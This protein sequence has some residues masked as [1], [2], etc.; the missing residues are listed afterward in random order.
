[1]RQKY[2]LYY[3]LY[4]YSCLYSGD[5]EGWNVFV[6][7]SHL[8]C[9]NILGVYKMVKSE[10]WRASEPLCFKIRA[11]AF[12]EKIKIQENPSFRASK[13]KFEPQQFTVRDFVMF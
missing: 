12:S 3:I 2:I 7:T 9:T 8:R 1:M 10:L 11:R 4:F 5:Q 13:C 6:Y